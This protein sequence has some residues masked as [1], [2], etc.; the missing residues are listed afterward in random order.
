MITGLLRIETRRTAALWLAPIMAGLAWW[1]IV[2]PQL[3][4]PMA[5]W[6]DRSVQV[7]HLVAQIGPLLAAAG[8]WMAGRNHRRKIKESIATTAYPSWLRELITCMAVV[9]WGLVVY[10][11]IGSYIM[12][13]TAVQDA[14]GPLAIGPILVGLLAVPAQGAMGYAIGYRLPSRVTAPLVAVGLFVAQ[15]VLGA[16]GPLHWYQFL[17]PGVTYNTGIQFGTDPDLSNLQLLFLLGLTGIAVSSL[18]VTS[19]RKLAAQCLLVAAIALTATSVALIKQ[20]G[21]GGPFS[22]TG[23]TPLQFAQQLIP[24]RPVCAH[25]PIPV[26]V[27]PAFKADLSA[28]TRTVNRVASPIA[29]LP[30]ASTRA[31]DGDIFQVLPRDPKPDPTGYRMRTAALLRKKGMAVFP[32]QPKGV[33][34]LGLDSV[35]DLGSSFASQ[36]A[37]SLVSSTGT[38]AGLCDPSGCGGPKGPAQEAIAVWLVQRAG[39]TVTWSQ[40]SQDGASTPDSRVLAATRRFAALPSWQQRAWL[41]RHFRS[42]RDGQVRL[43][44]VP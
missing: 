29:G 37:G 34:A 27:H 1:V 18:S 17:S 21:Q 33:V 2:R 15:N 35:P 3:A 22:A 32:A 6:P 12:S 38:P 5:S 41:G 13:A 39:F 44:D 31:L 40:L 4:S 43:T 25:A 7:L 42:L 14:W 28:I 11:V 36:L 23:V 30:G 20:N 26:C 19:F 10:L 8:A 24:F 16:Q 9:A